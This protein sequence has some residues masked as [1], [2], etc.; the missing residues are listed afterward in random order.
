MIYFIEIN[1]N[2][3]YVIKFIFV[4]ELYLLEKVIFCY[5]LVVNQNI[6]CL[7]FIY[8]LLFRKY[9]EVGLFFRV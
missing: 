9:F 4:V 7:L 5:I 2:Q 8:Y 1:I 3:L 6:I